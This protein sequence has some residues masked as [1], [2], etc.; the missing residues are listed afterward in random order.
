MIRHSKR[1][2]QTICI[3]MYDEIPLPYSNLLIFTLLTKE[4]IF[5]NAHRDPDSANSDNAIYYVICSFAL[6]VSKYCFLS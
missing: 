3:G 1:S 4:I 6:N 5:C 2:R